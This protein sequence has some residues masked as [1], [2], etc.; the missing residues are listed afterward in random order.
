MRIVIANRMIGIIDER[1][2]KANPYMILVAAP[3]SQ[4][5]ANSYTG[6]YPLLV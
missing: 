6:S 2:P 5:L 4:L 1:F 3:V